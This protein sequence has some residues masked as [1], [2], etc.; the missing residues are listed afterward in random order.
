MVIITGCDSGIGKV[1]SCKLVEMGFHVIAGVTTEEG[2]NQLREECTGYRGELSYFI[3]D[4]TKE[5]SVTELREYVED[6]LNQNKRKRLVG[7]VNNAGVV[8][9][10]PLELQPINQFQKQI[11]VNLIGQVRVLQQFLARLRKSKGRIITMSSMYGRIAGSMLGAHNASKHA[12]EAVSDT[13]RLEMMRFGVS[14][15]IIEPGF[16][17]TPML[18]SVSGGK[19]HQIW[20]SLLDYG[21]NDYAED[22]QKFITVTEKLKSFAG[23]PEDVSCAVIHALTSPYPKTRYLVGCDAHALSFI[24]W[25]YGDRLRDMM[26]KVVERIAK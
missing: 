8:L 15:S 12:M 18:D 24:Q 11:D 9:P 6:I 22:H 3:G 20:D 19:Q 7:L 14:V 26:I 5:Q 13:L 17:N 1:T 16:I 25:G 4:I 23:E 10:G 21:K 2:G